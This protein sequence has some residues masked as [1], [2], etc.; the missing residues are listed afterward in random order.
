MAV[1]E[2]G[3][4]N[5]KAQ[6][7]IGQITFRAFVALTAKLLADAVREAFDWLLS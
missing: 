6:R 2:P 1:Q 3:K 5:G 7:A 4:G